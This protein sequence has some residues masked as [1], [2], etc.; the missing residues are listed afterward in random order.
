M[1]DSASPGRNADGHRRIG[2]AVVGPTRLARIEP[3]DPPQAPE[4]K[5]ARRLSVASALLIVIG[6]YVHFCLYRKGYRFIPKIGVSFLLQF[7][8]SA[9]LAG[10]LLIRRGQVPVAG[11]PVALPQVIRLAAIALSIGDLVAL[12]LAHTSGG[13]FDFR[14]MGLQ[15]APQT[16]VTIVVES[17]TAVLLAVAVIQARRAERRPGVPHRIGPA[18]GGRIA[19]A[20]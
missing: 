4:A 13:L 5:M 17:L 7:S 3:P 2:P 14:E 11:R 1:K 9:L 8:A 20:A 10:L 15:P 16:L 12:G 6:G 18:E 19:D